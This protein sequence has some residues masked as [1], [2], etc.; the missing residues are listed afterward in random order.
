MV[1]PCQWKAGLAW[2]CP[3][4]PGQGHHLRKPRLAGFGCL[5]A[6]AV[7]QLKSCCLWKPIQTLAR[8]ACSRHVIAEAGAVCQS[9]HLSL[10]LWAQRPVGEQYWTSSASP[11]LVGH[12]WESA[13]GLSIT[14]GHDSH[15]SHKG[16]LRS[17]SS[18]FSLQWAPNAH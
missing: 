12:L 8:G 9:L 2:D 18:T 5:A 10:C 3:N 4:W 11:A 17:R 7:S 6:L 15:R 14:S 16:H 13:C 1:C